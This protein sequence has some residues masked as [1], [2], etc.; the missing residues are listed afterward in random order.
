MIETQTSADVAAPGSSVDDALGLMRQALENQKL[1]DPS[2]DVE[3]TLIY[4]ASNPE[5][6]VVDS[7]ASVEILSSLDGV[8]G[9]PLP[10]RILNHK[11]LST[12]SGLRKSLEIL[13]ARQKQ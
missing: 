7:F 8:F 2:L 4:A 6:S 3:A 10:K 12:L 9:T 11:S 13:Q 1:C 5:E